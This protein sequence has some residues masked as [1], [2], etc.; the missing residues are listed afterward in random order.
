MLSLSIC[1]VVFNVQ[2]PSNNNSSELCFGWALSQNW[3]CCPSNGMCFN[4]GFN[5]SSIISA[6]F[7]NQ[8]PNTAS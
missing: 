3:L 8:I 4:T 2:A 7:L 1:E 5:I 6:W